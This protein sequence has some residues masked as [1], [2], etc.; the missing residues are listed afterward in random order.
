VSA[1]PRWGLSPLDWRSHAI[2][3]RRDHPTWPL[4]SPASPDTGRMWTI[5]AHP[6]AAPC[7]TMDPWS[8]DPRPA[9]G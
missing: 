1:A 9:A 4:R 7:P 6:G 5:P 2:D 3:E 8:L